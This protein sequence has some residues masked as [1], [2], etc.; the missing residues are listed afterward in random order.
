MPSSVKHFHA[1]ISPAFQEE[2]ERFTLGGR[3]GN[4]AVE[5]P[6]ATWDTVEQPL[7]DSNTD[8]PSED[9]P[10]TTHFT[11]EFI[12]E[13]GDLDHFQVKDSMLHDSKVFGRHLKQLPTDRI[14]IL[15]WR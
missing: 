9:K 12:P 8:G 15:L 1:N 3:G 7:T 10:T 14:C 5:L 4:D 13:A 2:R 11:P 6:L